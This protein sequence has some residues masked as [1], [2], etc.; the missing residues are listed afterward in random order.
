MEKSNM[1]YFS[2][3]YTKDN[4]DP[5]EE[6]INFALKK[7][8]QMPSIVRHHH[9][10]WLPHRDGRQVV[11]DVWDWM[12]DYTYTGMCRNTIKNC[13]H[14]AV[15]ALTPEQDNKQDKRIDKTYPRELFEKGFFAGDT[16]LTEQ[17][18]IVM[19]GRTH[20][21]VQ[22]IQAFEYAKQL[23][24]LGYDIGYMS[25]LQR[26]PESF[27]EHFGKYFDQT[28]V[29]PMIII[30][31]G[32]EASAFK[33]T[34]TR[35][36]IT[37]KT[38]QGSLLG[39]FDWDEVMDPDPENNKKGPFTP[40]YRWNADRTALRPLTQDEES[41]LDFRKRTKQYMDKIKNKQRIL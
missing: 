23:E 40:L 36:R 13:G 30:Y 38:V 24:N 20:N 16:Q 18:D 37:D 31:A 39:P 27:N 21:A 34:G 14:I 11:D 8:L 2:I 25:C 1:L 12:S 5:T 26:S 29:W 15:W 3:G 35:D 10:I 7:A 6:H 28:P 9:R 4:K 17:T 32:T 33:H 19:W 41:K 22:N